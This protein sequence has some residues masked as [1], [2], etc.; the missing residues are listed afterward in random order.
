MDTD[1]VVQRTVISTRLSHVKKVM[2]VTVAAGFSLRQP[3]HLRH[4]PPQAKA[5]GYG[6][7]V[8]RRL[9]PAATVRTDSTFLTADSH[10]GTSKAEPRNQSFLPASVGIGKRSW[11]HACHS[12]VSRATVCAD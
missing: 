8:R 3:R 6:S 11:I 1:T 4:A 5:C 9:K 2:S 12:G 7:R 10:Q